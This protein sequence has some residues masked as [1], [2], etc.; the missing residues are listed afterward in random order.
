MPAVRLGAALLLAALAASAQAQSTV[1]LA[2]D[3]S[4]SP[5]IAGYRLYE[6]GASGTYTNFIDVGNVTS[7]RVSGL[8][9][10][11]T[12]FFA[13]T[14]YDTNN[15]ESDLSNEISYTVP[16][17][18]N[19]PPAISLTSPANGAVYAA[20]NTISLAASVTAN[21]HTITQVGFYNGAT[22][23][24][25]ASSAP[26]SFAWNK[27]ERRHLQPLRQPGL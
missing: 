24:G 20:G 18:T 14:A 11:S 16:Q 22:Q 21:G 2:W 27:C 8:V 26:Y 19:L 25:S 4:A 10:G 1:T 9:S 15:L 13:V 6:G 23:L 7:N 5:G 17:A 12:Y 3:P